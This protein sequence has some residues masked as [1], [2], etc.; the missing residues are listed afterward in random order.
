MSRKR[1]HDDEHEQYVYNYDELLQ[2]WHEY[3]LFGLPIDETWDVW[4]FVN[5][6]D[7]DDDNRYGRHT[8]EQFFTEKAQRERSPNHWE[9]QQAL[10]RDDIQRY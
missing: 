10:H 9:E 2:F 5:W 4:D 6:L 3:T 8:V 1:E 7:G